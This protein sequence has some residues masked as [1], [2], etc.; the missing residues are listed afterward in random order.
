VAKAYNR[1]EMRT[2]MLF[3][4]PALG[5]QN[6]M[7]TVHMLNVN[8]WD[9]MEDYDLHIYDSARMHFEEEGEQKNGRESH[10]EWKTR[11]QQQNY[12]KKK[13]KTRRN[14]RVKEYC[15]QE[16]TPVVDSRQ[17]TAQVQPYDKPVI[18]SVL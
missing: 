17:T 5:Q 13:Q 10:Q 3:S 1:R 18:K 14:R 12:K 15:L 9:I 4:T 7:T 8:A 16:L 11:L 6:L 2:P